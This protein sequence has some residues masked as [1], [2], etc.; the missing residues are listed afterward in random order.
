MGR[1]LRS[2]NARSVG[3]R[4]V[5]VFSFIVFLLA[6]PGV[7]RAQ[8]VNPT[9]D[10]EPRLASVEFDGNVHFSD[11][12]LSLRVRS[13]PNREFLG[14]PGF[15]WWL[16]IYRLGDS[17]KLGKRLSRALKASGEPPANLV[18]DAIA[19]DVERLTVFYRQEGFRDVAVSTRF[20]TRDSVWTH[21]TFV[22]DE[23]KPTYIRYVDFMGIDGLPDELQRQV[24]TES[25]LQGEA[26][27]RN[28]IL[29]SGERYS[30]PRLIDER[31]RVLT[32]LHN[33]G[34]A[35]SS[36]DSIKAIVVPF[37]KDSFDVRLVIGPGAAYTIGDIRFQISGP[38]SEQ[39]ARFDTLAT[40]PAGRITATYNTE[41]RL[42]SRLLARALRIA[43]GQVYDESAILDTK[44]RL[45]ATGVFAFTNIDSQFGD[46]N[47]AAQPIIRQ[48]F[49]LRTRRRHR[50]RYEWFMLQRGGALGGAD[51]ELGMGIAAAYRNTNLLGGG[52]ALNMRVAG[53]IAA[54]SD[55]KLFT[56]T[57]GELS[58]SLNYPYL[59]AP[60][61]G[62]GRRL[63]LYDVGTRL[64]INLLTARRDQLKLI[65]RGQGSARFRL[66]MNHS[67]TVRSLVDVF[68]ISI[69]NPDTLVG[70]GADFLDPLLASIK[71]DPVQRARIIEDY[72]QPQINDAVRYTFRSE[73]VNPLKRDEGYSYENAIEIG[74]T[75]MA[76]LD[77][78]VFSPDSVEGSL[79]GILGLRQVTN[80]QRL[81]Y[82]PYVRVRMDLR[83]YVKL[84]PRRV[85]AWKAIA[86]FAQ[87]TG[88]SDF[89]PF[90]RR[91][92]S[93]GA[94][95]VRGW[96]IGQ[97]GPGAASL[98]G[99]STAQRTDGTNL[100]G[101]DVKLEASI[102]LRNVVFRNVLAAQWIVALFADAG[103]VWFGPSNPG[104]STTDTGDPSGKFNFG[105]VY[106][107]IGVGSG[108]GLRIAWEYLIIR[109]DLAYKMYDPANRVGGFVPEGLRKP[110]LHF[111]IG[112]AF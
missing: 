29:A 76:A 20:D 51:A 101:G 55:F 23:G 91:F 46:S 71:N 102:E 22:I 53:S 1:P 49:D 45:E 34:Y 36:R 16:A 80:S 47:S 90:D 13:K 38:D 62:L 26:S 33:N 93:G 106:R 100:L 56:S 77:R 82:R 96:G 60:F 103:N 30:E 18:D 28:R 39:P 59:I 108:L 84:T 94:F 2:N 64:S 112:H 68:D 69:S 88:Q 32:L 54:D 99:D 40:A 25:T 8:S 7:L 17:G 24:V 67:P 35:T 78:F 66:D 81:I 85:V 79:P 86:G 12:E 14:I 87:P 10:R 5:V 9:V 73:N 6:F 61:R 111:G 74:G 27:G 95:S 104:F 105:T 3:A 57:Q 4:P 44:R 50:M 21:V 58:V 92:F 48:L 31:R 109:F 37:R 110:V 65:I 89:V 43:P 41:A 75:L 98:V 72:T 19:A 97:L 83:Q 63:N 70:F 11:A 107:E 42:R 52:E 15:R